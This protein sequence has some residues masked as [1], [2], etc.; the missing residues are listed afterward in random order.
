MHGSVWWFR[1]VR[2]KCYFCFLVRADFVLIPLLFIYLQLLMTSS[3]YLWIVYVS[4]PVS[5]LS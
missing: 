2:I 1:S 3:I 4:V 5:M